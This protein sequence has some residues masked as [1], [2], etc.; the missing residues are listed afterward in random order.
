MSWHLANLERKFRNPADIATNISPVS[1]ALLLSTEI[2]HAIISQ[3]SKRAIDIVEECDSGIVV[4]RQGR[5]EAVRYIEDWLA[6]NAESYLKYCDAYFSTKDIPLLRVFLAQAPTC[7]V[8]ILASKKTLQDSNSL[9][10][11]VFKDA[12]RAQSDQSPPE[13]EVIALSYAD[14]P[15][16][17]VHDRWLLTKGG[18]L[19]LGTSF[20]S[21]GDGKL[22]EISEIDEAQAALIEKQMDMYINRQ[23]MVDGARIQYNAFTLD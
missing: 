8:F 16:H 4:G 9:S 1:E 5:D 17:V 2:A 23:R 18:G 21:L 12:W 6:A 19:R 11:D 7:K 20:N 22:S 15:K 3:A 14:S 10:D 13:T